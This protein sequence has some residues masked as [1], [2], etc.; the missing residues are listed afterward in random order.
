MEQAFV[1]PVSFGGSFE[2]SQVGEVL[3]SEFGRVRPI[4]LFESV[5]A[6]FVGFPSLLGGEGAEW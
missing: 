4:A 5:E 2:S 3:S 1:S 6:Y